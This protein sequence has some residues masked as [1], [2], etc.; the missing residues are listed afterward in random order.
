MKIYVS[1]N[2]FNIKNMTGYNNI[3]MNEILKNSTND[4]ILYFIEN[5]SKSYHDIFDY[6]IETDSFNN[7]YW[8]E[9][10]ISL[11]QYKI[12]VTS[13]ELLDE[14]LLQYK[15]NDEIQ[16]FCEKKNITYNETYNFKIKI[17]IFQFSIYPFDFYYHLNIK[18]EF[19]IS[20]SLFNI[21][22]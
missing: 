1:D 13:K 17:F 7:Y 14:E 20:H 8:N 16:Y 9:N 21:L 19:F 15:E 22:S 4:C 11:K 3:L 12:K 5:V 6:L 18:F 10:L 2:L